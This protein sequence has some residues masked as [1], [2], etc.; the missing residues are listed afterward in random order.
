MYKIFFP[1]PDKSAPFAFK[2]YIIYIMLLQTSARIFCISQDIGLKTSSE[3]RKQQVIIYNIQ[4]RYTANNKR[5]NNTQSWSYRIKDSSWF[6]LSFY[7]RHSKRFKI[8]SDHFIY[9]ME[10]VTQLLYHLWESNYTLSLIT[11]LCNNHSSQILLSHGCGGPAFL[12]F[13]CRIASIQPY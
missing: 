11:G 6:L 7:T 10:K 9:W 12:A 13:L 3:Q 1:L 4:L 5:E 8:L 2:L